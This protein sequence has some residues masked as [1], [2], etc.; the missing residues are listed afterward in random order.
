MKAFTTKGSDS[1]D[2]LIPPF[3]DYVNSYLMVAATAQTV[4][5]PVGSKFCAINGQGDY[6]CKANGTATVP[7]ANTTDGSVSAYNPSQRSRSD[8]EQSFSIISPTAQ[9]IV[10]EF[11]GGS[12][13]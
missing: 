9:V 12:N 11:W 3:S 2:A 6:Y 8:T 4:A 7:A 5:W 1:S 13:S 10:I